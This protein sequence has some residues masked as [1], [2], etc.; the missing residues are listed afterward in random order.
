MSESAPR[1]TVTLPGGVR[2]DGR[3]LAR[4]Q[5]PDGSWRYEVA[6]PVPAAAVSPVDGE[7]YDQVPTERQA[8]EEPFVLQALR[9]DSPEHRALVLHRS[10]ECWATEG[11]RTGATADEAAFFLK[12]GWATACDACHPNPG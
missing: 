3:L 7:D 8:V 1:V 2:V 11:R 4:R 6:I 10:G 9:H 12:Q 5:Q